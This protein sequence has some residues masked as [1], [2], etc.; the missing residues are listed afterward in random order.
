MQV[1]C[2]PCARSARA[3]S[4]S[5][6][7]R[8]PCAPLHALWPRAPPH[9]MPCTML[10]L[11]VSPTPDGGRMPLRCDDRYPRRALPAADGALPSSIAPGPRAVRE[12]V[13]RRAARVAA[14]SCSDCLFHRR[15][16]LRCRRRPSRRPP[17]RRSRGLRV[18]VCS[19]GM[20]C[21][22]VLALAG[23]GGALRGFRSARGTLVSNLTLTRDF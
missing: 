6:A 1:L 19:A 18:A 5:P 20:L 4:R 21:R 10:P 13:V 9:P 3:Q 12:R 23:R 17:S 22:P 16:R 2:S 11:M 15:G 14:A 8:A 7:A